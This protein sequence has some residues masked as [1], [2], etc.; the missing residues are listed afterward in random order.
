MSDRDRLPAPRGT[1][2]AIGGNEDKEFGKTVLKRVIDLPEGGTSVVEVIPTASSIPKQVGDD[3][4]KAF[5]KLGI[6]TVN[7]MDIQER[8]QADRQEF[9]DRIRACDVAFFTGGDQ[10]R[11]TTLLGG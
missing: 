4:I 8:D 10:L 9:A 5:G 7:I 3:Y 1:L 6:K 2:V 11:I